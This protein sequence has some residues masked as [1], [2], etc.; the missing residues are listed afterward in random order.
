MM[1]FAMPGVVIRRNS[2]GFIIASLPD[3][4]AVRLMR[5]HTS[6][7]VHCAAS[8]VSVPATIATQSQIG[9]VEA[10]KLDSVP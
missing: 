8:G 7:S 5:S 9:A 6:D 2:F 10:A 4:P 1:F 3:Q